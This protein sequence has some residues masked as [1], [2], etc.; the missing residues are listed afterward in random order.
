MNRDLEGR[1]AK[2]SSVWANL[3]GLVL[4]AVLVLALNATQSKRLD[5][6]NDHVCAVYGMQSDCKTPLEAK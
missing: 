1:Y 2:K 5:E 3:F 6:Y 4:L